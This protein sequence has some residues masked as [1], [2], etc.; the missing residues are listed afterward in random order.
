MQPGRPRAH[1]P[2]ALGSAFLADYLAGYA[3]AHALDPAWL[4]HFP[5]FLRVR[6]A[7]LYA[8][9]HMGFPAETMPEREREILADLRQGIEA[10]APVVDLDFT[11]FAARLAPTP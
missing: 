3:T 11:A 9:L 7:V 8:A 4:A 6:R 10:D 5:L 1:D 2:I